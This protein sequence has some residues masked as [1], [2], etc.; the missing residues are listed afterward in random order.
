MFENKLKT[1]HD[2]I[3]TTRNIILNFWPR[4]ELLEQGIAKKWEYWIGNIYACSV[5]GWSCKN[6]VKKWNTSEMTHST[7][8]INCWYSRKIVGHRLPPIVSISI[9]GKYG[10]LLLSLYTT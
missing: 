9:A 5:A 2:L 7:R 10:A 3:L 1:K 8:T 6:N 4:I